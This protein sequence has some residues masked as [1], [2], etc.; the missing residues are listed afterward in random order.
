MAKKIIFTSAGNEGFI[1]VLDALKGSPFE[2]IPLDIRKDAYSL[3]LLKN[4]YISPSRGDS[5]ITFLL[6]LAKTQKA[7]IIYPLSTNDQLFFAKHLQT[8]EK[9]GITVLVSPFKAVDISNDK[10]KFNEFCVENALPVPRSYFASNQKEFLKAIG[11]LQGKKKPFVLKKAY[12]TGASGVKLIFPKMD[13]QERMFDRDNIRIPLDDLL[14]WNR[15]S[16]IKGTVLLTE[17]IPGV[18]YS[19]DLFLKDKK[20]QVAVVRKRIKTHYGLAIV[21]EVVEHKKIADLAVQTAH[22]LGL[23]HIV[24]IQIKEDLDGRLFLIEVNPRIPGS[25]GLTIAAGCN[26]P[27]WAL[28]TAVGEKVICRNPKIGTKVIRYFSNV[29]FRDWKE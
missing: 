14:S 20:V 24:N 18:E 6:K 23:D 9:Q 13:M 1:N 11:R 12:S 27:L 28:K 22:Q 26:M 2:P 29:Y 25:I 17:Y 7:K 4:S 10:F 8:F 5:F 16:K 21:A 19:V 3:Y 15:A